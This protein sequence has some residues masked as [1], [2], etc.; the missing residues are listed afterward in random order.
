MGRPLIPLP[1]LTLDETRALSRQMRYKLRRQAAGLCPSC[2]KPSDTPGSACSVCR[3]VHRER[4]RER[5]GAVRRNLGAESY[6]AAKKA[7][8]KKRPRSFPGSK[9]PAKSGE[10][11]AG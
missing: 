8:A 7:S 5:T 4:M 3:A 10:G 6:A 11:S 1:G 9:G 2:G